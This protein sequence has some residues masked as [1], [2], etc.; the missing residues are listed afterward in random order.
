VHLGGK[1]PFINNASVPTAR[2]HLEHDLIQGS[3]KSGRRWQEAAQEVRGVSI[4]VLA[5]LHNMFVKLPCRLSDLLPRLITRHP[6]SRLSLPTLQTHSYFSSL[7]ISTLNFL[8]P[9]NF[10]SK[11]REEKASFL[12]GLLRVLP[13]FS[14][15]LKRRKI[16]PSLLD[17]VSL[18]QDLL[19]HV[20]DL[21]L[22]P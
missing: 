17:E 21:L 18:L 19:R 11:P 6:Q 4:A 20:S 13:G 5:L 22:K 16:L 2:T 14:D 12:R 15:R 9:S 1:P 3:W 10:A 8:D 7:A